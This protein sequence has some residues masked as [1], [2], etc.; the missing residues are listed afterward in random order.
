MDREHVLIHAAMI[1]TE[2]DRSINYD[3]ALRRIQLHTGF[4][5]SK[6]RDNTHKRITWDS[7]FMSLAFLIAMRSPDAQTQHGCVI[8]DNQQRV[9]AT[10]YNGFLQG[11]NDEAMPNIRPK[12]YMHIIHSEVNAILSAR[13]DL[14][15]CFMYVTG[16]PCNECLKLI[17]RVGIKYITVGDRPHVFAEG[18]LEQHALI[19]AMHNLQITKFAGTLASLDGRVI[20]EKEA[21]NAP[22]KQ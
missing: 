17:A 13:Q 14:T 10:G 4:M 20:M 16:L 6:E 11:A 2:R 8:V 1:M 22:Q 21:K 5:D 15:D 19:C 9:V 18:Y 7:Y 3:D 12:K